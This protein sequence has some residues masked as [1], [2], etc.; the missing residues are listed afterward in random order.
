MASLIPRNSATRLTAHTHKR[1]STYDT[2]WCKSETKDNGQWSWFGHQIRPTAANAQRF[3]TRRSFGLIA[4][5]LS[6]Y[7]CLLVARFVLVRKIRPTC[8]GVVERRCRIR[9]T[10]FSWEIAGIILR[11]VTEQC[12]THVHF[13]KHWFT[14]HPFKL[15]PPYS[16]RP[17][18][19]SK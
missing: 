9:S 15:R 13:A 5:M 12:P 16:P 11:I 6:I 2:V 1:P 3:A 8:R 17:F 19:H 14:A 10:W 4:R 7:M 18:L